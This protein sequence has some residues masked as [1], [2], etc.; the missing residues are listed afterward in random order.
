[1]KRTNLLFFMV[2]VFAA[3]ALVFNFGCKGKEKEEEAVT[4]V[5][6]IAGYKVVPDIKD[7]LA[8][9]TPTEITYDESLLNEEQK[10]VLEKLV[11]AARAID[12]IF[13]KQASHVG[14]DI[15]QNFENSDH[16]AAE[17]FVRYLKINF[18]PYD[19]LDD[20]KPFIGTDPKPLGAG[21]YPPD[22]TKDYFEG[23][24]KGNRD[25]RERLEKKRKKKFFP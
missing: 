24:V 6:E 16:P 18:G 19:R 1:M 4:E 5:T 22:M 11:L 14:L 12:N 20:N 2:I 25:M 10:E 3:S 9:L 13:W 17:D 21:F 23:Y 8:Q 7:R 15:L